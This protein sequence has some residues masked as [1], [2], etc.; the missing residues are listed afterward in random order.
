MHAT[1]DI[2]A[3][4]VANW[5]LVKV[6]SHL[7]RG[8]ISTK[9]LTQKEVVTETPLFLPWPGSV[10]LNHLS[11]GIGPVAGP[12]CMNPA[13]FRQLAAASPSRFSR[14]SFRNS[15]GLDKRILLPN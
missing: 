6:G 2:W 7:L 12:S 11:A 14:I 3:I 5:G 15:S 10:K 9:P 4:Y 8:E 1:V 13:L